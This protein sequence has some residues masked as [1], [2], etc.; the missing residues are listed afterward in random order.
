MNMTT[1]IYL[2]CYIVYTIFTS[3][4]LSIPL[5][6]RYLIRCIS[7]LRAAKEI[8]NIVALYEGTV[9][10]E[11]RHPVHHSFR[12]PARYALIDL[13]RP[14]YSPPNFLSAEDARRAAKTN[15]PV[16]L[17]RIPPSVG[18]ERSPVNLYYCYDMEAGS[19][20]TLKKCI[21]EPRESPPP[22]Y[23]IMMHSSGCCPIKFHLPLIGML[24]SFGGR[25]FLF[26]STQEK[27]IQH[28]AKK[29]SD[30]MNTYNVVLEEQGLIVAS[31]G[32]TLSG[33]GPLASNF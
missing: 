7:P 3:T 10:H 27:R 33:L 1:P 15:G 4:I 14:P 17:L 26:M 30:G 32:K 28:I 23:R 16:F 20:K 2:V 21:V 6:L 22:T 5:A 12:F 25:M 19:T 31:Y 24:W 13:D 29:L 8:E 18:Y 11:R 9:H